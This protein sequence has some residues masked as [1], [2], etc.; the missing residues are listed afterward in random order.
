MEEGGL[1]V[2]ELAARQRMPRH[3]LEA[4]LADE[5]RRGHVERRGEKWV[6]TERLVGR[7][8]T[9]FNHLAETENLE[10]RREDT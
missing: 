5:L 7:F 6:A 4:V 1:T 3:F 2:E 9:A 8:G 10:R